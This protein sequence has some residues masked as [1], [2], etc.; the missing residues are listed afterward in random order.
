MKTIHIKYNSFFLLKAAKKKATETSETAEEFLLSFF[1]ESEKNIIQKN[2]ISTEKLIICKGKTLFE[3]DGSVEEK[4]LDLAR[5]ILA[6]SY[7]FT[8]EVSDK[9]G[10]ILIAEPQ[11]ISIEIDDIPRKIF[12]GLPFKKVQKANK[13]AL[14]NPPTLEISNETLRQTHLLNLSLIGDF[15]KPAVAERMFFAQYNNDI[16]FKDILYFTQIINDEQVQKIY[17]EVSEKN[18]LSL[19]E[20]PIQLAIL[21]LYTIATTNIDFYKIYSANNIFQQNNQV[22]SE[23]IKQ[24]AASD[25]LKIAAK[26]DVAELVKATEKMC[27]AMASIKLPLVDLSSGFVLRENYT[28]YAAISNIGAGF[29]KMI[30]HC[31]DTENALINALGELYNNSIKIARCFVKYRLLVSVCDRVITGDFSDDDC[32]EEAYD[33]S[34]KCSK[35]IYGGD[36]LEA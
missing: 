16:F 17:T 28:Y 18:F 21:I 34:K 8:Y 29:I 2:N 19:N 5:N 27:R 24:M 23:K 25:F 22:K 35:L 13:K 36:F 9:D 26:N 11:N 12:A 32:F 6:G 31:P 14:S 10:L 30:E 3:F 4:V 15:I 1:T 20:K 7:I 33:F